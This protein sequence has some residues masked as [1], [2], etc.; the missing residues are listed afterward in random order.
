MQLVE[1]YQILAIGSTIL[2]GRQFVLSK[3]EVGHSQ[4]VKAKPLRPHLLYEFGIF[5]KKTLATLNGSQAGLLQ[6]R[7]PKAV[8]IA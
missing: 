2:P 1:V 3:L 6:F 7:V 4:Q 5:S 8:P